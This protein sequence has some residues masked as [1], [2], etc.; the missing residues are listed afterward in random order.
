MN[1]T[2]KQTTPAR[3][4][5]ADIL[6]GSANII[7]TNGWHTHSLHDAENPY[8]SL[9]A[10]CAV[11]GMYLACGILP[12]TVGYRPAPVND[13][14]DYFASWL[15]SQHPEYDS[16]FRDYCA[17][18]D[19]VEVADLP[20]RFNDTP[21]RIQQEVTAALRAAANCWDA[22]QRGITGPAVN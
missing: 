16:L 5:I 6:R 4:T 22:N 21:D 15:L 12:G 8:P 13:A 1:P 2:Q 3:P 19:P 18:L 11:G 14:C 20:I 17:G 9:A 7:D 10:V